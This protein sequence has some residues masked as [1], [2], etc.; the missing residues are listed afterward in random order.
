MDYDYPCFSSGLVCPGSGPGHY[1][2]S[3]D[4]IIGVTVWHRITLSSCVLCD[5]EV[6][7]KDTSVSMAVQLIVA[8][9][10]CIWAQNLKATTNP[11][12]PCI[13]DS[14]VRGRFDRCKCPGDSV[15]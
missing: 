12:D 5:D 7:A 9:D 6:L 11:C 4:S 3:S 13:A 2:D 8:K 14:A 15:Q 1:W 10:G